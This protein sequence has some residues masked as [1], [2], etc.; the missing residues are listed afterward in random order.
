VVSAEKR[1]NGRRP[2]NPR[3]SSET[4]KPAIRRERIAVEKS[5]ANSQHVPGTAAGAP[6]ARLKSCRGPLVPDFLGFE[7]FLGQSLSRSWPNYETGKTAQGNP[8]TGPMLLG[9]PIRRRSGRAFRSLRLGRAAIRSVVCFAA[10]K[11]AE[12]IRTTR[13]SHWRLRNTVLENS[14]KYNLISCRHTS[15][16]RKEPDVVRKTWS[17]TLCS[18]SIINRAAQLERRGPAARSRAG[19]PDR[20]ISGLSAPGRRA[21]RERGRRAGH[22]DQAPRHGRKFSAWRRPCLRDR[23]IA[24]VFLSREFAFRPP[25]RPGRPLGLADKGMLRQA[26]RQGQ[27]LGT[28]RAGK[29][30]GGEQGLRDRGAGRFSMVRRATAAENGMGPV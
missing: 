24:P 27:L 29:R 14:L 3:R 30:G 2:L 5:R 6:P 1:K 28:G 15:Y 13:L 7:K 18:R 26:A 8:G 25:I 9:R 11:S 20:R 17:H 10:W 19:E 22:A 16:A 21:Q 12:D 4:W 23:K